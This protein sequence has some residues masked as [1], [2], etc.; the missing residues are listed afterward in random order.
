MQIWPA[1]IAATAL[2][3]EQAQLPQLKKSKQPGLTGTGGV[4][5]DTSHSDGTE[6][7]EGKSVPWSHATGLNKSFSVLIDWP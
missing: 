6:T 5:S 4:V 1:V 3:L 2:G 7:Q